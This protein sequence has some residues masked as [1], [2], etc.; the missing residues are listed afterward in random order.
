M[1]PAPQCLR[2]ATKSGAVGFKTWRGCS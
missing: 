1:D 2:C